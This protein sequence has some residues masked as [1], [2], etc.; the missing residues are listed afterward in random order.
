[1]TAFLL[2]AWVVLNVSAV[3][4]A[5]HEPCHAV[6]PSLYFGDFQF[7]ASLSLHSVVCLQGW[8]ACPRG[9]SYP[10]IAPHS[11]HWAGSLCSS[12]PRLVLCISL[13]GLFTPAPLC[14]PFLP[15]LHPAVSYRQTGRYDT[16][17][18]DLTSLG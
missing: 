5:R 18:S 1:M 4:T 11:P 13:L 9:S 6:F 12:H 2:V 17:Y 16:L 15:G 3:N 7:L 10:P 14:S 8:T